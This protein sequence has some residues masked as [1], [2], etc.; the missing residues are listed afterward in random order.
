MHGVRGRG[1]GVDVPEKGEPLHHDLSWEGHD[2][3]RYGRG[4]FTGGWFFC[5]GEA[6]AISLNPLWRGAVTRGKIHA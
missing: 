4:T 2:M 3:S 5:K 1:W 6:A